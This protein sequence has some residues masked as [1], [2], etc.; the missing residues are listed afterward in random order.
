MKTSVLL[1]ALLGC[2]PVFENR[3]GCYDCLQWCA[4][5]TSITCD[6]SRRPFPRPA[7]CEERAFDRCVFR[8]CR[9]ACDPLLPQVKP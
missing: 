2:T 9:P 7:G 6:T 4:E 8:D 1:L 5:V 3:A